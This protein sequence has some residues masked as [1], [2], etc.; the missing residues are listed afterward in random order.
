MCVFSFLV[1]VRFNTHYSQAS[2]ESNGLCEKPVSEIKLLC[3][4]P[5]I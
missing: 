4:Y 3:S 2:K 5:N 1:T